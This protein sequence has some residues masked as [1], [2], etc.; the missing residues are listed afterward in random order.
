MKEWFDTEKGVLAGKN[1]SSSA[2]HLGELGG[3]FEN[4]AARAAMDQDEVVYHVQ[5]HMA[6]PEGTSGGLFFGISNVMPGQVD[7][8]YFM[9]KGHFHARRE[10]AEYY[11]CI[12][13]EGALILMDEEGNCR[14]EKME[15]GTL[16]YIPGR[17][18][19]RLANTGKE[20]LKVGACWPSD[21]GHDYDSIARSG[22]TARLKEV[23]GKPELIP[24]NR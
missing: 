8:E 15:R 9:T 11:W 19:H 6:V 20:V 2:R 21:A 12:S 14:M 1:V 7:G 10:T 22:F 17:I 4:E 5:S 23:N 24:G 3:V 16:H 18:A 13:G